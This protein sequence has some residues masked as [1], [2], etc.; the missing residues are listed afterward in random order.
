[1]ATTGRFIIRR[2][3]LVR[4]VDDLVLETDALGIGRLKDSDLKLNHRTVSRL[5]A[6]I[7]YVRGYYWFNNLSESNGTTINGKIVGKIPLPLIDGD[8]IQIGPYVLKLAY[9]NASLLITVE[10]KIGADPIQT[11]SGTETDK[12][13]VI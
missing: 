13:M 3:D 8:Q 4:S 11:T 6:G 2:K 12:T 7:K 10:L 1:M 5:H 9:V